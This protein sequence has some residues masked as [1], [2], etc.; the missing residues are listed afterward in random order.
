MNIFSKRLSVVAL[1]VTTLVWTFGAL[2]APVAHA[3]AA[4]SLIKA[5]GPAVYYLAAD[6]KRYT[7]PNDKIYRSWY[8][9]FSGVQTI[10][11]AELASYM[12]GGN[13]KYRAGT[14]LV[15]ITTDPRVYAVEPNG[16]LRHISDEATA[17]ALYGSN[18]AQMVDDLPDAFFAPPN[19]NIGSALT[20]GMLPSGYLASD[21]S[22]TYYI[23]G[24]T[25]RPI[26]GQSAMDANRFWSMYVHT[27]PASTLNAF[28]NG[29]SINGAD[30]TLTD[31]SQGGTGSVVVPTGSSVNVALASDTP[32][33]TTLPDGTIYNPLLKFNVTASA[34]GDAQLT[35]VTITRGGFIANT[36][37]SGVSVWDQNGVRHGGIL[38]ALTSDG[39]GTVSFTGEPIVIPAGQTRSVTVAAN[40]SASA[41]SATVNFAVASGAHLTFTNTPT[42]NGIFPVMGNTMSVVDGSA[43]VG[44]V[45]VDGQTSVGLSSQP[46]S[47]TAG[48]LEVGNSQMEV[49]KFNFSETS[50]R[51]DV[52]V[53]QL[54]F[55]VQGDI[56]EATDL[57]NFTVYGPDG[58]ALGSAARATNRYVTVNLTSPYTV[59][60]GQNR[61]LTVKADVTGGANRWFRLQLQ[62]DYD[63]LVRG[64]T[65]G[66]NLLPVDGDGGT[67]TA[68][69]SASGYFKIKQGALTITKS[70]ASPSGNLTVGSTNVELARFDLTANGEN[71]EVRKL[72]IAIV[73]TVADDHGLSGNLS[74]Q[75]AATG[76][77]YF[78]GTAS[79]SAA[80]T[81]IYN[82]GTSA[83]YT[84]QTDLSGYISLTVGQVKTLK[85]VGNI[86]STAT[87]GRS[88]Q[89]GLGNAYVRRLNSLDYTNVPDGTG[90]LGNSLTV[91]GSSSL[92][93]ATHTTPPNP[94]TV[95]PGSQNATFATFV[96]G[97]Q[98]SG[99][100]QVRVNS[101]A[102]GLAGTGAAHNFPTE[103]TNLK[104]WD[105]TSGTPVQIGSTLSSVATSSNSFSVNWTIPANTTKILA[106]SAD[107]SSS[108]TSGYTVYATLA[109]NSIVGTGQTSNN[110]VQGPS[111]TVS[112]QVNSMVAAAVRVYFE[113]DPAVASKVVIAGSQNVE[114]G[115]W[116]FE[117]SNEDVTLNK[118]TFRVSTTASLNNATN[119]Q[120]SGTE[121]FG[122]FNLYQGSTLLGTAFMSNKDA[123]ITNTAAAYDNDG[124]S[125]SARVIFT[126]TNPVTLPRGVGGVISLKANVANSGS[127]VS[128]SIAS[129][130]LHSNS[131]SFLEVRSA[132]QGLLAATSIQ[133]TSTSNVNT[134]SRKYLY[135]DVAPQV[136]TLTPVAGTIGTTDEIARFE[137]RNYGQVPIVLQ[138]LGF[139]VT[140]SGLTRNTGN[141]ATD[142]VTDFKLYD[143]TG[144]HIASPVSAYWTAL[145]GG[146][147]SSGDGIA[148]KCNTQSPTLSTSTIFTSASQIGS[149]WDDNKTI[150]AASGGSY[151]RKIFSL[152]ANTL[153]INASAVSGAR[154]LTTQVTGTQGFL[155]SDSA[156]TTSNGTRYWNSGGVTYK[157]RAL[158]YGND[159]NVQDVYIADAYPVIG[160]ARTY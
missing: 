4:G 72:A 95:A 27:V 35:G 110:T 155:S 145:C 83:S 88:L 146:A 134:E 15:K 58:V 33:A 158:E 97:N 123:D 29:T 76:M 9:D 160:S 14:R 102:V 127:G 1:S 137:L 147:T 125:S 135:V 61:N 87:T 47:D 26:S 152:R 111:A 106:V 37:V 49:A 150:P 21:G 73:A 23:S 80:G 44:A 13:V 31:V 5:S 113:Q 85:V 3:V 138:S 154:T 153:S 25:K 50:S 79:T 94:N 64:V 54:V 57:A 6:G 93:V 157:F 99:S 112:G 90:T 70:S 56:N 42:V 124:A 120:A 128:S 52:T 71:L 148:G 103:L 92:T 7:F 82:E 8:S 109:S 18:W 126:L 17:V 63:V 30:A 98:S 117:V 132:S 115:R 55:Y 74:I 86:R 143:E 68:E 12:I 129:F 45:T 149:G 114:V 46:T 36:N 65:T 116:R 119:L 34:D 107:F 78:T 108:I 133:T 20:S 140:A 67:W 142:T 121:V 136:V 51:E 60:Q 43:S 131:N 100:E 141:T 39:M 89:I 10:S 69:F 151:G 24:S 105:I 75:D 22:T 104:L 122:A 2:Q 81:D 59:P 139:T 28:S 11:D 130:L 41:G 159:S 48:N 53:R 32:A 96:V 66:A 62:N 84:T 77:T 144:T 40:L 38:T 16:T 19:Y 118:I 91:G 101:I 156:S